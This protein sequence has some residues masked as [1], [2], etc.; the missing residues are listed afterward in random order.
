MS[1]Q[2]VMVVEDD[3][4]IGELI[5]LYLEREGYRMVYADSGE[6]SLELLPTTKPDLILLDIVLPGMSG[7]EVCMEVRKVS[8]IP[9]IFMSCKRDNDDIVEGLS[10]G[11]D[12][13]ITKPFNPSIMVARVKSNLRRS[14][15]LDM[16]VPRGSLWS[17]GHV[18]MDLRNET[19]R[20][21][22]KE[23]SLFVKERQLLFYLLRNP[24]QVFSISHLYENIWGANRES[25]ER[26]V[27]VHM[28]NLRRKIE[29]D[30]SRPQFLKTVRG[31]GYKFHME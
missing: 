27:M 5:G 12:D 31:I 26:T 6:Q 20:V 16:Q 28:S 24:N 19:V 2:T 29:E 9:I 25:D 23:I 10:L 1:I 21:H 17:Q 18:E 30:P 4:E 22:G 7:T 14:A 15:M 8:E 11:G 3:A 13:Y